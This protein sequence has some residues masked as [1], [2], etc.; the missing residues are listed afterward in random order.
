MNRIIKDLNI[1]GCLFETKKSVTFHI[2]SK[3]NMKSTKM[4]KKGEKILC[5]KIDENSPHDAVKG[6]NTLFF[7]YE[8]KILIDHILILSFFDIFNSDYSLLL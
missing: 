8:S 1:I 3:D 7:L 6:Y 4:L 2:I 5:I